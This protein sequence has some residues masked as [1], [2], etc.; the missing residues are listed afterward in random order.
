MNYDKR[1]GW[2]VGDTF[3]NNKWDAVQF[4]SDNPLPY[5]AY[6]NNDTW[7]DADWT[8]EPTQD[9]KELQKNHAEYLRNKYKTLVLFF[10]GGIDSSTVLQTFID[11]KIPLDYIC[12]WY[13]NEPEASYNKDVQLAMEFLEKNKSKLMGAKIIYEKKLDHFEG[14]SI[15]NFKKPVRNANFQL[16][17]HHIGNGE[18]LKLRCPEIYCKVEE[19]GC[20]VT[21]GNKPIVY[22]DEK[23]FYMRLIDTEEENW[24]QPLHEMFWVG[25]DPALQIKQCHLAKQW[26]EKNNLSNA[27]SIYKTNDPKLC[28]SFNESFGRRSIH[29]FFDSKH[30][31][32]ATIDDKC[33][34][35]HYGIGWGN[36]FWADYFKEWQYTESY[37]N[38]KEELEKID[39]KFVKNCELFGWM[40]EKRYLD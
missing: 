3:F 4:A 5:N 24:G 36:N 28:S 15:Y 30:C 19:N 37:F 6:C 2:K 17:F 13:V 14:N 22:K 33:F 26:L 23:G 9:I 16:R 18:S 25:K 34:S 8:R 21:G 29:E 11:N 38:L 32:G 20:I 40:T 35:Q 7:D 31:F 12:V 39:E 27:D 1:T 10:S